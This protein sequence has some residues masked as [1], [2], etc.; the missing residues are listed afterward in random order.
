MIGHRH[1]VARMQSD[2][3]RDA[4]RRALLALLLSIMVMLG[5]VAGIIY[6]VLQEPKPDFYGSTLS[7]KIIPMTPLK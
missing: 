2:F 5:L 4:Y 6:I 7:G 3:Y 1:H